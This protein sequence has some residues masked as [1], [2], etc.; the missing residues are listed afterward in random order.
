MLGFPDLQPQRLKAAPQVLTQKVKTPRLLV[1]AAQTRCPYF[2]FVFWV[3]SRAV[4]DIRLAHMATGC[5]TRPFLLLF[6]DDSPCE[7]SLLC[8]TCLWPY[9]RQGRVPNPAWYRK[10]LQVQ[11]QV[12]VRSIDRRLDRHGTRAGR[13]A[14][15]DREKSPFFPSERAGPATFRPRSANDTCD[16]GIL[17]SLL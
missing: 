7:T 10:L 1:A 6:R 3:P 8:V 9:S 5:A 4:A 13:R 14:A 15:A 12:Q 11:V 2:G 16:Y 17:S